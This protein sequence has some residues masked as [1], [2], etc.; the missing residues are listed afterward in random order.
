M[1]VYE[2]AKT[3]GLQDKLI[4]P[5]RGG[6]KH[7]API[8]EG[9]MK[10][11]LE[12]VF[13]IYL[14]YDIAIDRKYEDYAR[15]FEMAFDPLADKAELKKI[16]ENGGSTFDANAKTSI[17]DYVWLP[18]TFTEPDDD[19]PLGMVYIDW[20]DEWRIEDYE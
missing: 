12:K 9:H 18:I 20:A 16:I 7:Y 3:Y 8:G 1:A 4:G 2:K 13:N 19:H 10:V 6:F 17:A 15:F 5:A 11:V 14:K